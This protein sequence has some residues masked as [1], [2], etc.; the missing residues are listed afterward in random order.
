[1]TQKGVQIR[2]PLGGGDLFIT[3]TANIRWPEIQAALLS[4]Q[5]PSDRPDLVV[6]V[7]FSK[8]KA[9]IKDIRS[10]ALGA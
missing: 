2:T 7:I 5:A 3:I 4:G 8:L 9:L 10:G 1:M 6:R